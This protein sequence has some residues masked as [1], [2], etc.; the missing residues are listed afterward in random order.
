MCILCLQQELDNGKLNTTYFIPLHCF[1]VNNLYTFLPQWKGLEG[2]I[3]RAEFKNTLNTLSLSL[4]NDQYQKLWNKY[5]ISL[6]IDNYYTLIRY[7]PSGMGYI[8]GQQL[9]NK[10]GVKGLI[11]SSS[12]QTYSMGML[13]SIRANTLVFS[14]RI[15]ALLYQ[16][17]L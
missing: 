4:T 17:S 12:S 10:L 7:D 13:Y 2:Q 5:T 3:D 11:D 15:K 14:L 8:T 1:S 16:N 9:L 6:V